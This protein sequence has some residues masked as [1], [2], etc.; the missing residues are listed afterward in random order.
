MWKVRHSRS[1]PDNYSFLADKRTTLL[2]ISW[3]REKRKTL[4]LPI[5]VELIDERALH[6]NFQLPE[7]TA[8]SFPRVFAARAMYRLCGMFLFQEFLTNRTASLPH[9]QAWLSTY[10]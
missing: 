10:E 2:K 9:I 1:C 6:Q 8:L 7:L 5:C 4:Q 3:G